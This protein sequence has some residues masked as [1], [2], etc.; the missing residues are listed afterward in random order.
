MYVARNTKITEKNKFAISMQ[1]LEK[2]VSDE[3]DILHADK[4]ES[5]LKIDSMIF[6]GDGQSSSKF[7]K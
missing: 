1:Y 4:H 6:E 5:F 2:E 7:P 3:V